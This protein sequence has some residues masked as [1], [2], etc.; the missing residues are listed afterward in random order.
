MELA[1][2]SN[3]LVSFATKL[4]LMES[5]SRYPKDSSSLNGTK[6][7][8]TVSESCFSAEFAFMASMATLPAQLSRVRALRTVSGA[9]SKLPDLTVTPNLYGA[10]KFF[11]KWRVRTSLL[12]VVC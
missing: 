10:P 8:S 5:V 1:S 2:V 4:T 6:L 12:P 3:I 7:K 9:S 11:A